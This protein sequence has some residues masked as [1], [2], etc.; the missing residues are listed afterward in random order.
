MIFLESKGRFGNFLFQYFFAKLIQNKTKKKIIVFSKNENKRLSKDNVNIYDII[1]KHISLP[2]F[3]FFLNLWKKK[4]YY[5]NDDNYK[6]VLNNI[7]NINASIFYLD[8]FFH[9]IDIINKNINVLS[10]II[11]FSN[12]INKKKINDTDLTIHIRHIQKGSSSIDNHAL[13]KEQPN[14]NFYKKII[15]TV[16]PEKIKVVCEVENN[17]IFKDLKKLYEDKIFYEKKNVIEDFYDII[18]SKNLVLANSTFSIWG[19]LFSN[20]KNIYIPDIGVLKKI[21]KRKKI[22]IKSKLIYL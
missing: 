1:T 4:A 20:C 16:C 10:Q 14:L 3:N 18:N 12:L 6:Y 19:G 8:G 13:Y 11:N 22:N 21:L 17:E 15:D 7:Q 2:K 9:D 5:V